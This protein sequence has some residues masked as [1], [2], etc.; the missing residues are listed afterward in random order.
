MLLL[1]RTEKLRYVPAGKYT[2]PP[3][4]AAAASMA[5][6][7]EGESNAFPS[8]FAP[9]A[10]ILNTTDERLS[11]VDRCAGAICGVVRTKKAN[12]DNVTVEAE[13]SAL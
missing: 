2:V 3:P 1:R 7:I 5:L 10:L 11:G 4:F 12:M 9:Y 6:F 8:P 13:A